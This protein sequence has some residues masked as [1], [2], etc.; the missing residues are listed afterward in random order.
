MAFR[1]LKIRILSADGGMFLKY[2]FT[3][4]SIHP[5]SKSRFIYVKEGTHDSEPWEQADRLASPISTN[6]FPHDHPSNLSGKR[7]RRRERPGAILDRPGQKTKSNNERRSNRTA[8]KNPVYR[9]RWS[10]RTTKQ[11]IK[12]NRNSNHNRKRKL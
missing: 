5:A 9:E 7:L 11:E 12:Q 6:P 1:W 4:V 8:I 3:D 10:R 2:L